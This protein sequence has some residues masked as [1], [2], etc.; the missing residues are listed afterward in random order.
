MMPFQDLA[1]SLIPSPA[2]LRAHDYIDYAGYPLDSRFSLPLVSPLAAR[3]ARNDITYI[4]RKHIRSTA[5]RAR[6]RSP[7][8]QLTGRRRMSGERRD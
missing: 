2:H 7:N 8:R 3:S 5:R 1:S 6:V 4:E